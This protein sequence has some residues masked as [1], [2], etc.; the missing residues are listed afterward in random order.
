[1]TVSTD[2][3]FEVGRRLREDFENGQHYYRMHGQT[4]WMPTNPQLRPSRKAL[5]WHQSHRFLA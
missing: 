3:R 2:G 5:E 1:V 4:V